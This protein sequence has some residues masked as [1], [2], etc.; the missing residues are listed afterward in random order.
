MISSLSLS[1][2]APNVPPSAARGRT[3]GDVP[4]DRNR[5]TGPGLY[6]DTWI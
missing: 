1:G 6:N 4:T 3:A 5:A 2:T